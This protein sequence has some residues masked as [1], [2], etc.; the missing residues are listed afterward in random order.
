MKLL[1]CTDIHL[2]HMVTPA[3]LQ[4]VERARVFG[5]Y[6]K[7]Q[8][9]DAILITGDIAEA[10]TVKDLLSS[11]AEGAGETPIAFVLGNHDHYRGSIEQV[12]KTMRALKAPNLI[13]MDEAQP[14]DL[15]S[16]ISLVGQYAWYDGRL[17]DPMGSQVLLYDFSSVRELR[18][19]FK[20]YQWVYE[21]DRGGRYRLLAKLR[22]L[23]NEAAASARAKLLQA[24]ATHDKVIFLTHVAP[25][26]G[27]SWHMGKISDREWLPWFSCKT[28]GDMLEKVADAHPTKQILVLCG[29]NHSEGTY[30]H[31][32][33]LRVLTGIAEYGYP[34][35]A[36]VLTEH[37]F[38]D[39][40]A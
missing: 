14:I 8:D 31:R 1:W 40:D 5:E 11:F 2:D 13:W 12:G 18:S 38:E 25:Y 16:G 29:H 34:A 23:A 20:Q 15:G 33:N 3:A 32:P 17:G 19:E 39:W 37:S 7:T 9:P 22:R 10:P 21:A 27:A 4:P 36:G 28:M 6:L 35:V 30:Q 26:A 24:L